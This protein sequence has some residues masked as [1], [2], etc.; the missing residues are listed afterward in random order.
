MNE[1]AGTP[2]RKGKR[3]SPA[4]S[5]GDS[6]DKEEDKKKEK[7]LNH[8]WQ[9]EDLDLKKVVDED[10]DAWQA[11]REA[12]AARAKGKA[13]A[14]VTPR[15]SPDR[16]RRAA[17]DPYLAGHDGDGGAGSPCGRRPE[18]REEEEEEEEEDEKDP[19]PTSPT[20]R[21]KVRFMEGEID[22]GGFDKKIEDEDLEEEEEVEG[23]DTDKETIEA[24][25]V[26]VSSFGG[27]DA[28]FGQQE[29]PELEEDEKL[30]GPRGGGKEVEEPRVG[31]EGDPAAVR[32]GG[33]GGG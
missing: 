14:R 1:G 6:P 21:M 7:E 17:D 11:L 8:I 16:R 12:S 9:E 24:T 5:V 20:K 18:P 26:F 10:R 13:K 4:I 33:E 29:E 3:Q 30:A 32:G 27:N 25:Q 23:T 2:T 19:K 28:G 15:G 22:K 31:G